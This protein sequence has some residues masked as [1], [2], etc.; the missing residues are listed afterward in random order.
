MLTQVSRRT[1]IATVA[2]H[3]FHAWKDAPP[4]VSYLASRHRHIFTIKAFFPVGHDDRDVEFHIAQGWITSILDDA[5]P[6]Q[7]GGY[8]FFNASCETI[9]RVVHDEL[10]E[11]GVFTSAVEVW[12][13]NENGARVEF[14]QL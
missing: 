3:G 8:D 14:V 6:K 11:Q 5:Y 7:S 10:K 1:V 2:V 13:D 12:E 4:S 9:A